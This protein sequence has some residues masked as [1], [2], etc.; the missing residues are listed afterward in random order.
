MHFGLGFDFGLFYEVILPRNIT[1]T[2]NKRRR[3]I[4][5]QVSDKLTCC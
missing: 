1:V 2:Q 4:D 3:R 5:L